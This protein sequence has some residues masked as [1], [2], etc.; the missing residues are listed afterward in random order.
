MENSTSYQPNNNPISNTVHPNNGDVFDLPVDQWPH[1]LQ[2]EYN[3]HL[4]Q[5]INSY[6][7]RPNEAHK[8]VLFGMRTKHPEL[9]ME[10]E[11]KRFAAALDKATKEL[12]VVPKSE[13][14]SEI[15]KYSRKLFRMVIGWQLETRIKC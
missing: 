10:R 12:L 9:S 15:G 6:P 14:V 3:V 13:L 1:E 5:I 2:I 11:R 4:S 7:D 8:I